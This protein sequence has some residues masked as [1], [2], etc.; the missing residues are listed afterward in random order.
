ML[1]I[2]TLPL[3]GVPCKCWDTP[4]VDA[5]DMGSVGDFSAYCSKPHLSKLPTLSSLE[6]TGTC[7][8]S[9]S[10]RPSSHPCRSDTPPVLC[11]PWPSSCWSLQAE[12]DVLQ[13]ISQ[14]PGMAASR[15]RPKRGN[16]SE[17]PYLIAFLLTGCFFKVRV[18]GVLSL[19]A[20]P[21]GMVSVPPRAKLKPRI[22]FEHLI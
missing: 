12:A 16:P 14:Q 10:T 18:T 3:A 6:L 17:P 7:L 21:L 4:N 5:L 19:D 11:I 8:Q 1:V 2:F 20:P 13:A 9:V 15:G 22:F